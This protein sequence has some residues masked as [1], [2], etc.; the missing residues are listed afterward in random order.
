MKIAFEIYPPL[1]GKDGNN[2]NEKNHQKY[3]NIIPKIEDSSRSWKGLLDI[4]TISNTLPR[5]CL[6]FKIIGVL[7]YGLWMNIANC[8]KIPPTKL[9]KFKLGMIMCFIGAF[10]FCVV[11]YVSKKVTAFLT[12]ILTILIG[13]FE[14]FYFWIILAYINAM[15]TPLVCKIERFH[16]H[17]PIGCTDCD[18][19]EAS[20]S[21]MIP[22]NCTFNDNIKL[23]KFK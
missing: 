14:G 17:Y 6:A 3:E 12:L 23:R 2:I 19:I 20:L 1:V 4:D 15:E 18:I 7:L 10:H 9:A 8:D 13:I 5:L 16:S 22:R 21:G 11:C